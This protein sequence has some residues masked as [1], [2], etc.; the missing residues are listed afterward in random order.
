MLDGSDSCRGGVCRS[1]AVSPQPAAPVVTSHCQGDTRIDCLCRGA[2]TYAKVSYPQQYGIYA[3]IETAAAV[4]RFNPGGEIVYLRGKGRDWPHPQEW[5]KR[6]IGDDWIYYS[7]GGYSGVVEAIGEYYLPNTPY[8][9]NSLLGGHPFEL[10]A[11]TRLI[12]SWPALLAEATARLLPQAPAAVRDFLARAGG[13]DPAVLRQRAEELFAI[14]G[15]RVTV[16]PPDARHVDYDLV[17]L[18]ISEGCLYK[19]RFCRVKTERPYRDREWDEVERQIAALRRWFGGNTVNCNSLFLGEHDALAA[20]PELIIAAI[21]RA[22][23]ELGLGDSVMTGGNVFLFGSVDSLLH[24][25][26]RL[27]AELERL[28]CSVYIN[29]GL[30]SVD[31]ETLDKLGK[32]LAAARVVEAFH[33]MQEINGNFE[34][35]EI[36]AN[37]VMDDLAAGHLPAMLQLLRD[38]VSRRRPK[39]SIYL[40]PLRIGRPSR[41]LVMDFYRLKTL[42]RLPTFLYIIQ[43]L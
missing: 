35:I 20:D 11:V 38:G 16:L 33:R 7:T 37:F 10:D 21:V 17:P 39:G 25:P 19:C 28:P 3:E 4:M 43:R 23:E 32:P 24:A 14:I 42:S 2:A 9:T 41:S 34:R 5:L 13:C 36:T 31:Q 40:S 12:E 1:A 8:P 29:I 30:E 26:S 18:H 6:T 15:G 22:R 27:F